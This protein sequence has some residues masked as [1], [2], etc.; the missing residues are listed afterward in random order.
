MTLAILITAFRRPHSLKLVLERLEDV[1]IPIY[2]WLNGPQNLADSVCIQSCLQ[3]V[4]QSSVNV[5]E[6][7]QNSSYFESG[8]SI[9]NAISWVFTNV[10]TAIILEDDI[11]LNDSALGFFQLGL[12]EFR[13]SLSIASLIGTS[14]LPESFQTNSDQFRLTNF[15]SSWGWATWADKWRFFESDLSNWDNE[16]F[17]WPAM[18][19]GSAIRRLYGSK[20][21]AISVGLSDAWDYR[22]QYT[23]WRHGFQS[24]AP[25]KNLALNIGFDSL[26]THTQKAPP[27]VPRNQFELPEINSLSFRNLSEDSAAEKWYVD[28]VLGLGITRRVRGKIS[29]TLR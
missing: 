12:N 3:V 14:F 9:V 19:K 22:W 29:R 6:V 25:Y 20:F 21:D 7:K 18:V 1:K 23:C 10:E 16:L 4:K 2:I 17:E 26:A 11:L 8:Q 5:V 28:N 15:T 27:W 24:V 13:S